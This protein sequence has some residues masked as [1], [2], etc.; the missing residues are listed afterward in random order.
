MNTILHSNFHK[1]K[2]ANIPGE[3]CKATT[4]YNQQGP[5]PQETII[6]KGWL[7][8][9]LPNGKLPPPPRRNWLPHQYFTF[10]RKRL[11][12]WIPAPKTYWEGLNLSVIWSFSLRT[13][14]SQGK[15]S[16]SA[17]GNSAESTK[18]VW[19]MDQTENP[20]GLPQPLTA[21][22]RKA[23]QEIRLWSREHWEKWVL[24]WD[25]HCGFTFWSYV[26]DRQRKKQEGI[27]MLGFR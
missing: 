1:S 9:T 3:L 6:H 24:P 4:D 26:W 27:Q 20:S 12:T 2:P 5:D 19:K 25:Q 8:P 15:K 11:P 16:G 22:H 14:S 18:K 23:E 7:L 10:V 21:P 17:R 13:S